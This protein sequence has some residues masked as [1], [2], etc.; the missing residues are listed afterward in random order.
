MSAK[1]SISYSIQNLS[2]EERPRERLIKCGAEA[3]SSAE[4]LAIIFG[5]GTRAAPVLQLSQA[6]LAHFGDLQKLSEA[7]LAELCQVKGIGPGKALQLKAAINLGVRAARQTSSQ[8]YR[9]DH[10]LHAYHLVKERL[11]KETREICLVIL[12][13]HK[14]FVVG[15]HIVALGALADA[16]F[17]P[18]EIFYPAIRHCAASIILVHNHPSGDPT[19]SEEDIVTTKALI[20]ASKIVAIPLNDHLV[21][22]KQSFISLRQAGL[23][24][25]E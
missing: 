13:D 7:S 24:S 25:F 17:H 15:Q 20:A 2:P 3:L 19:P 12:Q 8:K 6:L 18:R 11:E 16:S 22:G 10:P 14:G 5:S 23:L 21:I 1:T 4:L 9:I